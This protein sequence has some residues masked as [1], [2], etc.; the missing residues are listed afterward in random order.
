VGVKGGTRFL[1]SGDAAALLLADV[2]TEFDLGSDSPATVGN[3]FVAGVPISPLGT[4]G[5]C[6]S[7]GEYPTKY[8]T[9][10]FNPSNI[11]LKKFVNICHPDDF[12]FSDFTDCLGASDEVVGFSANVLLFSVFA[13][14]IEAICSFAASTR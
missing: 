5:F 9:K 11:A 7:F 10:F 8:P 3:V 6:S 13:F 2:V 4:L 12:S 1:S 14:A